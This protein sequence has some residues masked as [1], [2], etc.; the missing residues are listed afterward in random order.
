[1]SRR[2]RHL[3]PPARV[4]TA[5]PPQPAGAPSSP[6]RRTVLPFSEG[7]EEW[8]Q[9]SGSLTPSPVTTHPLRLR[10]G[11]LSVLGA[12]MGLWPS[13]REGQRPILAPNTPALLDNRKKEWPAPP[14]LTSA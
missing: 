13:E 8:L 12:R 11:D 10:T 3:S 5:A 4:T 1:M 14:N 2:Q 6:A 9:R 7:L